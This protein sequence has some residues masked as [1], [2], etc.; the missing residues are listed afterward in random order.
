MSCDFWGCC[1][2]MH[3]ILLWFLSCTWRFKFI[4]ILGTQV[5]DLSFND[6]KGPGFEP[7]ANCKALQVCI[8]LKNFFALNGLEIWL[9]TAS[10]V[11][12]CDSCSNSTL[13]GTKLHHWLAFRSSQIWRWACFWRLNLLNNILL[14]I[15]LS[16]S[17]GDSKFGFLTSLV[18]FSFIPVPFCCSK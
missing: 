13:L 18:I 4:L 11:W 6:F 3:V 15:S 7:L 17:A 10:K 14:A 1:L 5:L 16:E 8:L 12:I 2:V 9:K